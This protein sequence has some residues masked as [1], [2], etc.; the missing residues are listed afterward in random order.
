MRNFRLS[1][2]FWGPVFAFALG[3]CR[4]SA[5]PELG[6]S[7]DVPP[8]LSATRSSLEVEVDLPSSAA[9]AQ[10]FDVAVYKNTAIVLI[11]W[12]NTSGCS[13]R[14]ARV[15]FLSQAIQETAVLQLLKMHAK[16]VTQVATVG[17]QK[18]E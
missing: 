5:F 11:D 18:R 14:H 10:D 6:G 8:H 1:G 15:E 9:C 16:R 12:R 2:R 13:A 7:S 17:A 4:P 3:G